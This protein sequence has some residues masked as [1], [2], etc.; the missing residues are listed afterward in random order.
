MKE[1][2]TV[3]NQQKTNCQILLSNSSTFSS[4]E[5]LHVAP[6]INIHNGINRETVDVIFFTKNIEIKNI[7]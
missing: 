7:C 3:I 1:Q 6:Q 2:T 5:N 4:T